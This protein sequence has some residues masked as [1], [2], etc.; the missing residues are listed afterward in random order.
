MNRKGF[1][2]Q[3]NWIFVLI[4][5][6]LILAFFFTIAQKQRNLSQQSV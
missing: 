3:F 2:L 6:A 1:E 5:G 4:A